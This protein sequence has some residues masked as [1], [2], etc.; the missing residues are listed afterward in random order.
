MNFSNPSCKFVE[1]VSD[2]FAAGPSIPTFPLIPQAR[3]MP[4]QMVDPALVSS[5]NTIMAFGRISLGGP[6]VK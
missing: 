2:S 4:A 6:A 1:F 5:Y 3:F